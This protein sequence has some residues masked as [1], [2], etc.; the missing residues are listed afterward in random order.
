MSRRED[1]CAS[2]AARSARPGFGFV[3]GLGGSR[4]LRDSLFRSALEVLQEPLD[5]TQEMRFVTGNLSQDV[6]GQYELMKGQE[7]L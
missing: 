7:L 2:P 5:F 4:G 1:L 3:V 6:L